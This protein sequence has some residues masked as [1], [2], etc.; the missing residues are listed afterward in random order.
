MAIMKHCIVL[1][2]LLFHNNRNIFSQQ[3]KLKPRVILAVLDSGIDPNCDSLKKFRIKSF[4]LTGEGPNDFIGHGTMVTLIALRYPNMIGADTVEILNIKILNKWGETDEIKILEGL[5]I[6][7]ENHAN[8]VNLSAGVW[9]KN[10]DAIVPTRKYNQLARRNDKMVVVVSAGN[11]GMDLDQVRDSMLFPL[12]TR[13]VT[14]PKTFRHKD[15]FD[16]AI[17]LALDGELEKAKKLL[18]QIISDDPEAA[19]EEDAF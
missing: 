8:V 9:L 1:V 12:M 3:L 6:A 15:M 18:V 7:A 16:D 10:E 2:I 11:D 14:I 19:M 17:F 5:R 4:D 13:F